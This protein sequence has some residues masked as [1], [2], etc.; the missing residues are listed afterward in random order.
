MA[1]PL[2]EKF[3]VTKKKGEII[4]CEFE[5]GST[6]FFIQTGSVKI[7]K[8]VSKKEKT[9]AVLPAGEIFG[10]MA[11]LEEA[12]RSATAIVEEDSK[13]LE[14]DR[15]S[16]SQLVNA[17]PAIALKL[18]RIFAS[19]IHDQKRKIKIIAL[20]DNESKVMDVFLMLAEKKNL[21]IEE[22]REIDFDIDTNDLA[23]WAGISPSDCTKTLNILEKGGRI[24][25]MPRQ[26]K[27][28]NLYQ[29]ARTVFSKRSNLERGTSL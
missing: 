1:D 8:I 24:T 9:L 21:V 26:I 28:S 20:P 3:G 17:Q 25:V 29:F 15:E 27:V 10:E 7:T 19:R 14:L 11:I 22:T 18:L 23:S 5:P 16:F 2:F 12:P 6:L 13:M 4:F